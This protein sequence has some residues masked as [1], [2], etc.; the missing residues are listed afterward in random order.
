MDLNADTDA[1]L[2]EAPDT[3]NGRMIQGV[4][5]AHDIEHRRSMAARGQRI[6]R[7]IQIRLADDVRFGEVGWQID[8]IRA[9]SENPPL[10]VGVPA[11]RHGR[12]WEVRI[13]W[14][15]SAVPT[16]LLGPRVE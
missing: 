15:V 12:R 5:L 7:G 8:L 6:I 14:L 3:S 11:C 13:D 16:V 9:H 1:V 4:Q 10:T 2:V